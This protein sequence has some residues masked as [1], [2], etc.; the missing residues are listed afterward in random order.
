MDGID[1]SS[2]QTNGYSL[3]SFLGLALTILAIFEI[4][5]DIFDRNIMEYDRSLYVFL[6]S[7]INILINL[8]WWFDRNILVEYKTEAQKKL[9]DITNM[10]KD[11][12][13]G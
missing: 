6:Y 2:R 9:Y 7:S 5:S 4:D 13:N 3:K 10:K 12:T 11:K 8:D 1:S